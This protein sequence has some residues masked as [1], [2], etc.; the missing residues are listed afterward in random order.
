MNQVLPAQ[1]YLQ[2]QEKKAMEYFKIW[3]K[4]KN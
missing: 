1:S 4:W 3:F 2:R